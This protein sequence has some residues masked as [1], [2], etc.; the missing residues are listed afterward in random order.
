MP[1]SLVYEKRNGLSTLFLPKYLPSKLYN[2]TPKLTPFCD[3]C[4]KARIL[5][6][7]RP[8]LLRLF[9]SVPLKLH[10]EQIIRNLMLAGLVFRL[11]YRVRDIRSLYS[12]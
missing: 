9:E 3:F 6:A 10:I 12:G 7:A 4:R 2:F 1:N 8:H 11:G 5:L